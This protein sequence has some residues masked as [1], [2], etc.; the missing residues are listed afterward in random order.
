MSLEALQQQ[1]QKLRNDAA[2]ADQQRARQGQLAKAPHR[3][4]FPPGLF[5]QQGRA[6]LPYIEEMADEL[7]ALQAQQSQL[8]SR[9]LAV[10]M[11]HFGDQFAAMV[12]AIRQHQLT[13]QT[14]R[15]VHPQLRAVVGRYRPLYDK[16]KQY[17][18]FEQR[19]AGRVDELN[20][21]PRLTL[22]QQDDLLRQYQRLGKCRQAITELEERLDTLEAAWRQ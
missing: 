21:Q 11:E 18:E 17:R 2:A 12:R 10:R 4:L 9:A 6:F 8:S 15:A 20:R 5:H 7:A 14:G 22:A 3:P 16:L 13:D 19:L 1:L